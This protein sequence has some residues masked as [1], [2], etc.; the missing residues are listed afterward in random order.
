MV[1]KICGIWSPESRMA[2]AFFIASAFS[3]ALPDSSASFISDALAARS[4]W[5]SMEQPR[6]TTALTVAMVAN[7][8][9]PT[10]CGRARNQ[11][12]SAPAS[13]EKNAS[14]LTLR[15]AANC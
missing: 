3:C 13:G 14:A 11:W 7:P 15:P 2:M 9:R 12:K 10:P 8:A 5:T 1:M 6:S 4:K